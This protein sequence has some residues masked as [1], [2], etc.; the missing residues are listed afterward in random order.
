[1]KVLAAALCLMMVMDAEDPQQSSAAKP[2]RLVAP[3]DRAQAIAAQ[4]AWARALGGSVGKKNSVGIELVLIPPGEFVMGSE[5]GM[6][7]LKKL[8]PYTERLLLKPE[9]GRLDDARQHLVRIT[10]PLFIGKYEMTIGQFRQFAESTGYITE[11]EKDAQGGW[12]YDAEKKTILQDRRFHW[13]HTGTDPAPTDGHPVVNVS[14]RDTVAFCNWLSRKE[15]KAEYYRV[16]G[17]DV[18]VAGG[19]GYRLPTEAEWEYACRAGTITRYY[20][21]S[22]PEDLIKVGNT[23]DAQVLTKFPESKN[24]L[25]GNDGYAFTAP[26]GRYN[27]NSFGLHDTIG[28]VNEWCG[29]WYGDEY[30]ATIVKD[31]TGP[32]SGTKRVFRGGSW[33]G[34][35]IYCRSACRNSRVPEY[36]AGRLG[37]RLVSAVE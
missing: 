32:G 8:F 11:A 33:I 12:G 34:N 29:D 2:G 25:E 19:N 16:K 10:E 6:D 27:P 14:W 23:M 9:K 17:S 7:D 15:G 21:G 20:H 4:E 35:P 26:V 30:E 5:D 18:S 37:F 28:N 3:F 36:R 31:P 1:M 24:T 22:R 13:K